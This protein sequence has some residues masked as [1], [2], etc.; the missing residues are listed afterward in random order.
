MKKNLIDRVS[1]KGRNLIL[2]AKKL[3]RDFHGHGSITT[4]NREEH[5]PRV[6]W[7]KYG[8]RI[9]ANLTDVFG[10]MKEDD[11]LVLGLVLSGVI[12]GGNKNAR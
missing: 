6:Q 3:W 9:V 12:I 7:I 8:K 4:I 2:P 5:T 10:D 1:P 11:V